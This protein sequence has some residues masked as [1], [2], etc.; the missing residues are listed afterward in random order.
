MAEPARRPFGVIFLLVLI[1]LIGFSIIFPLFPGILA[2]Y[3]EVEG[4]DSLVGGLVQLLGAVPVVPGVAPE[5]LTTVLFGGILAALFSLLQFVGA[6]WLG[7]LSD[8]WGRRPVLLLTSLGTALSY[9][10]WVFAGQLWLLLVARILGGLMAGNIS[11]AS[12]AIADVT[13]PEERA[14]GMALIGLAFGLGFT[15]GPALGSLGAHYPPSSWW[16]D[17]AAWG[18]H[19]FSTPA[20]LACALSLANAAWIYLRLPETLSPERRRAKGEREGRLFA[21]FHP[22]TPAVARLYQVG[23]VY[24]LA[25]SAMEFSLTFLAAER[26]GYGPSEAWRIFAFIGVVLLVTQGGIVRPLARR[27]G[28]K[29]LALA[30][31]VSGVTSLTVLA[32]V[33]PPWGWLFYV[34]LLF[35]GLSAGLVNPSLS[36]MASLYAGPREQGATLGAYR[37]LSALGRVGG[38]IAGAVV[39]WWLGSTTL[40]AGCAL[41][42]LVPLALSFTLPPPRPPEGAP[43]AT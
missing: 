29:P 16:P 18:L 24:F 20:L 19:P 15:M 22:P 40:Y 31:M 41:I 1:D 38:P 7:A 17:A 30:G 43:V 4:P 21:L 12:A 9:L 6:P 39:Y 37:S 32:F 10:L 8:C 5:F 26:I 28:E 35:Q 33:Q 27:V 23:L 36:A 34:G 2:H 25:F 11:V 3:L 13:K 14:K 42:L